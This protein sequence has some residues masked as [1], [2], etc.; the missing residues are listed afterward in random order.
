VLGKT[1]TVEAHMDSGDLEAIPG[2]LSVV[3][4]TMT[5]TPAEPWEKGRLYQYKL[6]SSGFEY[7]TTSGF[8]DGV[9]K[10][11]AADN[12][13]C[14]ENAVCGADQL[15]LQTQAIGTITSLTTQGNFEY[16]ISG[17]RF[18]AGGPTLEQFFRGASASNNV[19]QV[20]A[21][22]PVSDVNYNFYHEADTSPDVQ[23]GASGSGLGR[24]R[25]SAP[26]YGPTITPDNRHPEF[27]PGGLMPAKNSA[28]VLSRGQTAEEIYPFPYVN[29]M[30]LGCAFD[31]TSGSTSG[32]P[33]DVFTYLTSAIVAE[34]TDQIAVDYNGNAR[35]KVLMWPSQV[36]G[37][38]IKATGML[39]FGINV[40]QV[41]ETGPQFLRMRYA[42]AENGIRN[43]PITAWIKSEDGKLVLEATVDLYLNAP[44]S[45]EWGIGGASNFINMASYPL[46]MTLKG[47]VNFLDDGRM[48]VEQYNQ[49]EVNIELLIGACTTDSE[50]APVCGQAG[51]GDLFIPSLGSRLNFVSQNI[52]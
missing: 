41:A 18:K 44:Y 1:F 40:Q 42:E 19:M 39:N 9:P 51:Y 4:K 14:G 37:T 48:V 2:T 31:F 13:E 6:A 36:A 17:P 30:N 50:G 52:K 24:Y 46:E 20:L 38:S 8:E 21:T 27:D 34:V 26:E 29:G 22:A 25:Y 11:I 10:I 33:K 43:Q 5:F 45:A 7:G 16:N 28:K 12:F 15:P 32:C 49:N 23:Y 47:G 35:I 3:G